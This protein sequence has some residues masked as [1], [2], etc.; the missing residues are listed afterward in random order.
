MNVKIV[1]V[2]ESCHSLEDATDIM[3][4]A[5]PADRETECDW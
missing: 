5:L 4:L 1:S 3:F 2:P